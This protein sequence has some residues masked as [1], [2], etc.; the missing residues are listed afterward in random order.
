MRA[1]GGWGKHKELPRTPPKPPSEH[2]ATPSRHCERSER[3]VRGACEV[4]ADYRITTERGDE[5]ASGRR[6]RRRKGGR[7][8][9]KNVNIHL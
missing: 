2:E 7:K 6:K 3:P 1:L 5:S 4:G 8:T 9:G